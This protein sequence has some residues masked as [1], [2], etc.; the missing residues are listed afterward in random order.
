[1]NR[2]QFGRLMVAAMVVPVGRHLYVLEKRGRKIAGE[3]EGVRAAAKAS[4]A[5]LRTADW[6][7][8]HRVDQLEGNVIR[9]MVDVSWLAG[10]LS[11]PYPDP[12]PLP[13]PG[14]E[15]DEEV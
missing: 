5:S 11:R 6:A 10:Q 3:L 4:D 15:T 1:M 8:E 12:M 13:V 7:L 9:L 2:R 14:N